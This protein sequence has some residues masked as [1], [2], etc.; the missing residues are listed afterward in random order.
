MTGELQDSGAVHE[1]ELHGDKASVTISFGG[2][3]SEAKKYAII[4]HEDLDAKHLH[5][6]GAKFL[7]KAITESAPF[8]GEKIAYRMMQ[9]WWK[10]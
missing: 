9:I 7:E 10:E 6:G 3:D 1:P 4:V 8:V 2:P 5:G